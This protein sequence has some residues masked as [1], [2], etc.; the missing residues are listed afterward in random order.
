V[1]GGG[2]GGGGVGRAVRVGMSGE[3]LGE[4]EGTTLGEGGDG[5]GEGFDVSVAGGAGDC[6]SSGSGGGGGGG[7]ARRGA[8]SAAVIR[9][10]GDVA[11]SGAGTVPSV[12]SP[13]RT[14]RIRTA[15]AVTQPEAAITRIWAVE[16]PC[17][18]GVVEPRA[19][20]PVG[21]VAPLARASDSD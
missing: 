6:A 17:F 8:S 10:T 21:L 2:G 7:I 20:L 4:D 18:V 11:T 14:M 9:G 13:A 19:A 5:G 1:A 15:S 12:G 16:N 3:T